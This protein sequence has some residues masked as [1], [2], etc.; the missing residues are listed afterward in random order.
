MAQLVTYQLG[1]KEDRMELQEMK[2]KAFELIKAL[3]IGKANLD[4]LLRQID[5]AEKKAKEPKIELVDGKP[6]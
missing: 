3:E 4:Q 5:E 2:A 6:A 1:H